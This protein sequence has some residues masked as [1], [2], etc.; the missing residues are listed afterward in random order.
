MLFIMLMFLFIGIVNATSIDSNDN[1]DDESTKTMICENNNSQDNIIDCSLTNNIIE[2][3]TKNESKNS[4]N[5]TTTSIKLDNIPEIQYSDSV[6]ISGSLKDSNENTINNATLSI[7]LNGKQYQTITNINGKFTYVTKANIV[8][9][10]N[11]T[12]TFH[13]DLNYNN[14]SE[15]K[16]YNVIPK[17]TK[18][19]INSIANTEYTDNVVISGRYTDNNGYRLILTPL[20]INIGTE[21]FIVKTDD[22]G[23]YKYN[24]KTSKIGI[25]NVSVSYP[26]NAHYQQ[27]NTKTSFTVTKKSTILTLNNITNVQ[28][29]D[30]VVI[31]GRYTDNNGYRLIL[32][33]ITINIGTERFIVKTDD[34]GYYKYNY[35][36][37]KIGINN[38][39][40]SYPGNAHYQQANTKTSFTV[41]KKSTILTLNNITNVQLGDSVVISG[42][43]TDNNGYRLILTPITIN[44]GTERFIVKT[45]DNGYYKYNY[46]TS[47]IGIN[48]VSVS[49]P[50]NDKYK[51]DNKK[52]T[53]NVINALNVIIDTPLK[54][55]NASQMNIRIYITY[56]NSSILKTINQGT[57]K[58]YIANQTLTSNVK[59]GKAIISH[60]LP[61][62]LGNY[63]I[64]ANYIINN[65][66]YSS[67]KNI[68]L[69][70][71]EISSSESAI[72]GNKDPKT[73]QI[74]ITNGIPNLVYMTNYVWADEDGT[75]TLTKSQIEEVFKQDSYSL[76][77]NKYMSKYVAFKTL[78]ESNIYHVLKREKW[79]VIEKAINKIRVKTAKG[80]T[81]NNITVNL[82]DKEYTYGEARAIQS[83]EYTCGPTATS[84]CTQTLRNYVNEHTL[85]VEFKTYTYTG[86]YAKYITPALKK[87]NMTAE[88][89]YKNTFDS[90]L[91]KLSN[92]GCTI[93]FYGVNHY[94]SIIDISKDKTKVLV[95]NSYG[96]YSLGGGKIPNGWVNVSLMKKRFAKDSFAGLL[97]KLNYSLSS[98]TKTNVNNLYNNFGSAWSRKNTKE[99]LNV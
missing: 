4:P 75:Y 84:V 62:K 19:S 23:Y 52:N 76:Y 9:K 14:T 72:L 96:N 78:N 13:G 18:L 39:S 21:R 60:K 99:E 82:K 27:A 38:V 63:T 71:K 26:G 93:V 59:Y 65:L 40:V 7:T 47:K 69:T 12:V 97:V 30:S 57:V 3:K 61:S 88:Y 15:E 58:V 24:Y 45:D 79:N 95:S 73:E 85:A 44:I 46:K 56:K 32:T 91:T 35:K 68:E 37:S 50:G 1:I 66:T 83:T 67:Q 87:H 86:T 81:P 55:K 49:Y 20:T 54:A 92:G 70:S 41:T 8:G 31:S 33:P 6:T 51:G 48:N 17:E 64:I 80:T 29:G 22:N 43:Y 11:L 34:N 10:N 89:I 16:N 77:L 36:T 90:A 42:R 2:K 53:F 25:N 28:L 5:K 74:K 94:V 98:S